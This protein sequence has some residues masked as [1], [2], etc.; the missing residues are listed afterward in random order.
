DKPQGRPE[1]LIRVARR[2]WE[3]ENRLH[4]TKD[5]TLAE[6]ADRTRLGATILARLRS[7]GVGILEHIAGPSAP[8][9][10]IRINA[11]PGIALKFLKRRRLPKTTI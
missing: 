6:D 9:K 3:I 2:H 11:N 8:Q 7:L 5:R 10:Q 1:A 4:H